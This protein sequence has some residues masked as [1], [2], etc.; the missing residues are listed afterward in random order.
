[1]CF[2][3]DSGICSRLYIRCSMLV[4]YI[5]FAVDFDLN[6][7]PLLNQICLPERLLF[8]LTDGSG[9]FSSGILTRLKLSPDRFEGSVS[10]V[11]CASRASGSFLRS[12]PYV[13]PGN[14]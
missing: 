13:D 10:M 1:M 4:N 14:D 11:L 6:L 8:T 3:A 12:V 7:L 9:T 2:D 5:N